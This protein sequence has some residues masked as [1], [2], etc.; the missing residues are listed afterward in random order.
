[1]IPKRPPARGWSGRGAGAA[2]NVEAAPE[3]RGSTFQACG[4]WP[5]SVGMGAPMIGVPFC[6]HLES[7]GTVCSDP[8]SWLQRAKLIPNPS[9]FALG[10]PGLDCDPGTAE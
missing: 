6:R 4:L 2:I 3:F 10:K 5:F 1:V 7:R 9:V 8:I